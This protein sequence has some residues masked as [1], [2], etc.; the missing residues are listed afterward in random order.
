MMTGCRHCPLARRGKVLNIENVSV[1]V[2]IIINYH[3]LLITENS[4]Y[5]VN[6]G[7][8]VTVPR[9][10]TLLLMSLRNI[11][12]WSLKTLISAISFIGR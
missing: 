7:R 10:L 9:L 1:I 12:N 6:A 2:L 4:C 3:K 5:A 8:T 11:S